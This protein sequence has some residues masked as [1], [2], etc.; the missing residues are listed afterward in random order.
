VVKDDMQ[1]IYPLL[2][3]ARIIVLASPIF[4]Y[5]FP[6]GLK[7]LI[8]RAQAKWAASQLFKSPQQKKSHT[9]GNG[10]L[11]AVGATKGRNLFEGAELTAR[12]FF[13]ALDKKYRGGLFFRGVDKKGSIKNNAEALQQAY[14]LG[15]EL[16]SSN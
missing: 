10:Y 7:A 4:F 8:D 6:A 1:K 11:I 2:D 14:Q 3:E 5:G 15:V 16:A 9:S 13:D 12:Y